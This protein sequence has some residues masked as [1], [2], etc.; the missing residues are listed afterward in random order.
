MANRAKKRLRASLGPIEQAQIVASTAVVVALVTIVAVRYLSGTSGIP[1]E[2]KKLDWILFAS[3]FTTGIFGFIIVFFTLKYGRLLEGQRQ[4]LLALNTISESVNRA[5]EIK[6]LFHNALQ[7]ILRVLDVEYGWIFQ[8]EDNKIVL[9]AQRGTQELKTHVL[10]PGTDITSPEYSWVRAPR[11]LKRSTRKRGATRE[12]WDYEEVD[13]WISVPV[14]MKDHFFGIIIIASKNRNAF[15]SKQ[16]DLITAVAN[17]IGVAIENATLF[18][19]L[20]KS[21]ERYMDLF[22]H[23]PDMYHIVNSEGIIISCNQTEADRLGYR[24]E[25]LVGH[26]V[27]KLYPPPYHTEVKSLL[28]EIFNNSKDIKGLGEQM[29][30][31]AGELID[32]SV[33]TSLIYSESQTP[34]LMRVVARDI[35]E[36]K[37]MEEKIFHAQRID[38][39]GNLAGGVAHDFNNILTSILGSTAIMKR[40]MKKHDQWYRIVDIVETAAKRGASLTRQLLTFARKSNVQFRPV[41][42][43]DLIDETLHLFEPTI[44]KT[45][46]VKKSLTNEV[47]LVNGD[48]GQIQQAL[49][50][51][52]INARDAMPDGGVVSVQSEKIDFDTRKQDPAPEARTGEYVAISVTDHG[53]GMDRQI[54]QRI[55]EPFFSTKDQGKGTGLGLAVVYGVVNSHNGFITVQSEPGIGSQFTLYFPLLKEIDRAHQRLRPTRLQ[56]GTEHILVVDDEQNVGEVIGGMLSNL[57]YQ[58]TIADGGKKALALHKKNKHFDAIILDMNMPVMGGKETF[59]KLKAID[60]DIRIIVSTGYSNKSSETLPTGASA[61]AFL[62][63]PY[64]LEELSSTIRDVLDQKPSTLKIQHDG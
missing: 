6:Y 47:C 42:L 43:N 48:D 14:M 46:T 41:I 57:G 50:N 34:I 31:S 15:S 49:L 13:A 19:R 32:V 64:Q 24:K 30:H 39:I 1:A 40:K 26:P 27:T 35:T 36:K 29:V 5:V 53:V 44:D 52:L 56:R 7:E 58:V 60:P 8:I 21:E 51:L 63:K 2:E 45:I 25:E 55:F 9:G 59:V 33:S 22:E 16:L 12:R 38:S 10:K 28:H 62:Q 61:D 23:S 54:Q 11:I 17:Q 37:K 4:E 3:V 20:R 18:D